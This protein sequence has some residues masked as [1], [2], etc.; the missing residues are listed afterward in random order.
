MTIKI[1]IQLLLSLFFH[2]RDVFAKA[3]VMIDRVLAG[4]AERHHAALARVRIPNAV[5]AAVIAGGAFD[6]VRRRG[7]APQ[8]VFRERAE[9]FC[10][11]R[12][13]LNRSGIRECPHPTLS[14]STGRGR[15]SLGACVFD[16]LDQSTGKLVRCLHAN[17]R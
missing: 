13:V 3:V 10:H 7:D 15:K 6:L 12:T 4:M 16:Q 8:E 14:R 9:R 1:G 2:E 11:A 5:P 17:T